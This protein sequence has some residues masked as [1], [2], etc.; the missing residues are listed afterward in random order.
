MF[1]QFFGS[2]LLNNK[3]V[4]PQQLSS[5]LEA[6]SATRVKLG[7]LAI[8]AGFMTAEQ[9]EQVHEKQMTVDKRMG[10][11]A[12]EMRFITEEQVETLLSSQKTGAL[13]IGQALVDS[14][15]LTNQQFEKALNNYKNENKITDQDFTSSQNIKSEGVISDFYDIKDCDFIAYYINLLF[16]NI[17]R[18]IGDDF[19]P[20]KASEDES[21]FCPTFACQ[22]ICGAFSAFTAIGGTDDS[23]IAFASRFAKENL[24]ANDAYTQSAVGEFMNLNNGLFTVNMSNNHNIELALEPQW[25]KKDITVHPSNKSTDNSFVLPISFTFG[26]IVFVLSK[27]S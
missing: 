1:T 19:T 6:K 11:I 21:Y 7:V 3:I 26:T 22:D 20:L 10:D 24:T 25:V 15:S 23:V 16:K 17:I 14:G 12:V 18:F 9:V 4:T 5:A 8:N 2:Y 13:L 27:I